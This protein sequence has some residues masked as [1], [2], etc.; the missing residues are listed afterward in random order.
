M[1]KKIFLKH[2]KCKHRYSFCP[3]ASGLHYTAV[4]SAQ[5]IFHIRFLSP[6]QP[7]RKKPNTV[8]SYSFFEAVGLVEVSGQFS[9]T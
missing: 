5:P 9:E 2:N 7:G 3:R 8:L 1:Y 6:Y 4:T